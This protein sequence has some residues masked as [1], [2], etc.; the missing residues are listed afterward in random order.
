M[1]TFNSASILIDKFVEELDRAYAKT[2]GG[3]DPEQATTIRAAGNMAME[4]IA[5]SDS[6]YH[7]V[8][9]SVM[10]T[11]VG[12][13]ILHGKH[14]MEG[15]VTTSDWTHFIVSLLCHDIGYVR[16][17]CVGDK[18]GYAVIDQSGKTVKIPDGATD[19]Y[20]TPYHVDRGQLFVLERFKNH[21]CIDAK[22]LAANISNTQFP[23]PDENVKQDAGEY[24]RLVQAADLIGQLADPDY[25]RKLPALF[26]EFKETGANKA[27]G[28]E[29]PE[30]LRDSYPNFFWN[31]VSPYISRGLF[32][33]KATREG[34]EWLASLYSHVFAQEHD[35]S[36]KREA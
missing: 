1:A 8:E 7:N 26:H 16:N 22:I 9:H 35:A 15:G 32:Y 14:L 28:C 31:F 30:D 20:L 19:A 17:V 23:V 3:D 21:P 27:I 33:L 4:I 12:Q 6:L 2:F 18:P 10:V 29:T 13:E 34:R 24:P 36:L 11:L 25:L 5:N